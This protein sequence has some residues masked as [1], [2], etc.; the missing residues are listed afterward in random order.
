MDGGCVVKDRDID[1]ILRQA[2]EVPHGVDP[3]VLNRVTQSIESSLRPVRPLPRTGVLAGALVLTC[4][5]VA[6]AGGILLGFHG[7]YNLSVLQRALIFLTLAI[8][9]GRVSTE[10][11]GQVIPGSQRRATPGVLLVAGVLALLG[12]FAILFHDYRSE[13]FV[14]QGIAC[15]IAGLLFA[16]PAGLAGWLVLRRGFAVD[17]GAAGLAAGTLAGL[18]GLAMLELHCPNFETFHV[19]LWHTAVVPISA[20]AGALLG[21]GLH[22][23]RRLP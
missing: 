11:V 15:L 13:Q 10:C 23:L 16:V 8:I 4:A 18:A 21:W 3:V 6:I 14:H 19:M 20:A 22:R 9:L 2:G 17:P 12:V 5:A 7:V 1:D